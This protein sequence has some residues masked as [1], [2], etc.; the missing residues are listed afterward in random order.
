[1]TWV[2]PATEPESPDVATVRM[3]CVCVPLACTAPRQ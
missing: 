3:K 1:M 2:L